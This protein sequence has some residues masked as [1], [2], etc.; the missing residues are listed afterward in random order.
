MSPRIALLCAITI[1]CCSPSAFAE[2]GHVAIF[3]NV[4]GSLKILRGDTIIDAAPGVTVFTADKVVSG[5]EA[6]AGIVFKDGTLVTV[7]SSSELQIREYAFETKDSKYAFSMYLA[8]GSAIYSSGKIGKLSPESVK[9]N[10]PT[11]T[12]GVR[13]TRFIVTAD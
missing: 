10:T 13:G 6:S 2:D 8:K 4:T 12:V 1:S 11:A 5:P 9:I 7:G 3:K